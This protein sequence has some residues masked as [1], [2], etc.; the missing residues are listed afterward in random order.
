MPAEAGVIE[1]EA[2]AV[3]REP[4]KVPVTEAV[5]EAV[6][7]GVIPALHEG[8]GVLDEDSV[9]EEVAVREG[10]LEHVGTS[11]VLP[12]GQAAGHPHETQVEAELAPRAALYVP[13]AQGVGAA[14]LSGQ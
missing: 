2:G 9:L 13:A 3:V 10:V 5:S 4:V 1:A 12:A 8:V 6:W 11:A 7:E 14:E